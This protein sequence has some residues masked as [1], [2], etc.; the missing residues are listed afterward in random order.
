ML[1]ATTRAQDSGAGVF[2]AATDMD[3]A[4]S[5]HRASLWGT[6][7]PLGVS[8]LVM[9]QA[10]YAQNDGLLVASVA[11]G[12]VGM[13][14]GPSFGYWKEGMTARGW[15]S[16]G[17]R[18]GIATGGSMIAGIM[19]EQSP[20]SV[21]DA[22]AAGAGSMIMLATAVGIIASGVRDI[23]GVEK[24]VLE[25]RAAVRT[26]GAREPRSIQVTPRLSARTRSAGFTTRI[27]F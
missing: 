24:A 20:D 22:S 13:Y 5:A 23:T 19:F 17:L 9:P 27:S 25:H 3:A 8:M 2:T 10:A 12:A 14:L 6:V 21:P 26:A 16:V 18:L 4:R 11:A 1:P 7:I 15:K